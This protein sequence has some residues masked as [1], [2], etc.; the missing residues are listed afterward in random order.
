MATMPTGQAV[1]IA[2][3]HVS[4]FR[5]APPAGDMYIAGRDGLARQDQARRIPTVGDVRRL[6]TI[7]LAGKW[8]WMAS[9][10]N[11]PMQNIN[12]NQPPAIRMQVARARYAC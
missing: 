12:N 4:K 11:L 10:N 5:F 6:Y 8:A 3:E 9:V 1:A 2:T 7:G